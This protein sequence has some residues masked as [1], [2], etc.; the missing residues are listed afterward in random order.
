MKCSLHH[1]PVS[2]NTGRGPQT[3]TKSTSYMSIRGCIEAHV[4]A[5]A[6][7]RTRVRSALLTWKA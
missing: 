5:R 4:G 6:L 7:V 1:T 2:Q 3:V